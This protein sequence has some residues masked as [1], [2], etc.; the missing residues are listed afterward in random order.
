MA[1]AAAGALAVPASAVG[2]ANGISGAASPDDNGTSGAASP[3]D[4]SAGTPSDT[5][6]TQAVPVSQSV[7]A[8]LFPASDSDT[9][10]PGARLG[11]GD[12]T[13][14]LAE[15]G[16]RSDEFFLGAIA[17]APVARA[18]TRVPPERRDIVQPEKES[19]GARRRRLGIPRR[20]T[21]RVIGFLLLFAGIVVAAYFVVRWYA[22]D[23][24]IV[25]TDGQQIVVKQGQPGGVLWFHPRVVD[26]TRHTTNQIP[27]AAVGPVK[28][29]VQE[30][31]LQA[32][33]RYVQN[34]VA[35]APTTTTTTSTSTSTTSTTAAP[36]NA[37]NGATTTST[38]A[39][40][41]AR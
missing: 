39:P 6:L 18:T 16:P 7:Q 36:S 34:L 8:P 1:V 12:E 10:A 40:G 28:A 37:A 25:T 2:E 27:P 3:D 15:D 20:V 22:Y 32:A 24:W 41:G 29:G 26:R 9:L 5:D 13:G 35:E 14:T 30:G 33:Q 17:G 19:R 38:T 31:S 4:S 23:N 21:F 11:F